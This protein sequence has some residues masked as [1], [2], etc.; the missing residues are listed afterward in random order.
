VLVV[1]EEVVVLISGGTD[2]PKAMTR[3]SNDRSSSSSQAWETVPTAIVGTLSRS[4]W[5]GPDTQ[6][7]GPSESQNKVDVSITFVC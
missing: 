1:R 4:A 6:S 5:A 3:V 7:G 2:E